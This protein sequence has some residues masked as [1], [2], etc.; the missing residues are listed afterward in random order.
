[1]HL[2]T[3]VRQVELDRTPIGYANAARKAVSVQE[4]PTVDVNNMSATATI[5]TDIVDHQRE[6]ILASGVQQDHYKNNPVVLYEHGEGI[7][8]DHPLAYAEDKSGDYTVWLNGDFIMEGTSFFERI[9]EQFPIVYQYFGLIEAGV[10]RA[11]SIHVQPLPGGKAVYA[12]AE[13]NKY[14]VTEKSDMIEWSWCKIGVNPEALKKSLRFGS[15]LEPAFSESYVRAATLQADLAAGVLR[16]DS[17]GNQRLHETVRKSLQAMTRTGASQTLLKGNPDMARKSL[18][19]STIRALNGSELTD[20]VEN[21][22]EEFD[23]RTQRQLKSMFKKVQE[24]H[25][26]EHEEDSDHHHGGAGPDKESDKPVP[27]EKSMGHDDDHAPEK[28]NMEEQEIQD[29]HAPDTEDPALAEAEEPEAKMMDGMIKAAD[30]GEEAHDGDV[31]EAVEAVEEAEEAVAEESQAK[32]DFGGSTPLGSQ[33]LRNLHDAVKYLNDAVE[34]ALMPVEH[35][36]VKGGMADIMSQS[37]AIQAAVDGLHASAYGDA[38]EAIE[39]EQGHDEEGQEK[40][41]GCQDKAQKI[42][43]T[44]DNDLLSRRVKSFLH[45]KESQVQNFQV[46]SYSGALRRISENT[47]IPESARKSLANMARGLKSLQEDAAKFE[48]AQASEKSQK[49]S[50]SQEE[51]DSIVAERDSVVAERDS[52]HAKVETLNS[53]LDAAVSYLE[54]IAPAS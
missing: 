16:R 44:A 5:C 45:R 1:M 32:M 21:R 2:H 38:L 17:L 14:Q 52:A 54:K 41:V 37:R 34:E 6:V 13:G 15:R 10:L 51:F 19:L 50:Y 53:K 43:D 36:D 30:A 33:V 8:F 20:I 11:T 9:A 22:I 39:E 35:P 28:K 18:T 31:A 40:A 48:E 27:E 26:E 12:D 7:T 23:I 29:D 25:G 47:D 4:E 49:K 46:I 3:L 24:D 42:N